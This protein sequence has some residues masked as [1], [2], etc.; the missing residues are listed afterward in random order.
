[1]K[2]DALRHGVPPHDDEA[3][4]ILST[5]AVALVVESIVN[6]A[7]LLFEYATSGTENLRVDTFLFELFALSALVS[8]SQVLPIGQVACALPIVAIAFKCAHVA[9]YE[10]VA[11]SLL[12]V[13]LAS[14]CNVRLDVVVMI[15]IYLQMQGRKSK[16]NVLR[17]CALTSFFLAQYGSNLTY[18]RY[19]CVLGMELASWATE[20]YLL[21]WRIHGAEQCCNYGFRFFLGFVIGVHVIDSRYEKTM[22]RI[23]NSVLPTIRGIAVYG[24]R[25]FLRYSARP[26]GVLLAYCEGLNL[27]PI[28]IF[29]DS[30]HDDRFN[31]YVYGSVRIMDLDVSQWHVTEGRGEEAGEDDTH[32]ESLCAASRFPFRRIL[33]GVLFR[34]VQPPP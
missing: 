19:L 5:T 31:V 9:V 32:G 3:Y 8:S 17:V 2:I 1:M 29:K 23:P 20:R 7:R 12:Y 21:P 22:L 27:V 14:P 33:V 11:I 15:Y 13:L 30:S 25:A 16:S 24:D 10:G 34:L 26:L 18:V 4:V 6:G 28:R